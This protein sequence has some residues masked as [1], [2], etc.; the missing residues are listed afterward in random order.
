MLRLDGHLSFPSMRTS[1]DLYSWFGF[2]RCVRVS[3]FGHFHAG[4]FFVF[5][6]GMISKLFDLRTITAIWEE[7]TYCD[8]F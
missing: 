4:I 2:L 8:M 5:W 3:C 1:V 7:S 6:M